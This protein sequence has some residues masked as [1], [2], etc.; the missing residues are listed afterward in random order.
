MAFIHGKKS[1]IKI[2]DSGATLRDLS[3]Y[4]DEVGFPRTVDTAE[5]T[6]FGVNAKAYIVGLSDGTIS[7][8]GQFDSASATTVDGVL[9]GIFGQDT[10][11]AFEY[12]PNNAVAVSSTNPKYTGTAI[13][14][15]YEVTSPVG[16]VVS[17]TATLQI[18]GA[19][20]RAI[21]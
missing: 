1:G 15:A 9:S 8:K 12:Y 6:P 5:V 2:A 14:T 16:D 20:T 17:F 10:P 21:V 18:T 19:V 13:L 3:A 4:C 7:L 11:V